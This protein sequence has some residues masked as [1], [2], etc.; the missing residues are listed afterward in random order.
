M[1]GLCS[2]LDFCL[3]VTLT[4]NLNV[5]VLFCLCIVFRFFQHSVLGTGFFCVISHGEG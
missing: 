2:S 5:I 3:D 4:V 1:E